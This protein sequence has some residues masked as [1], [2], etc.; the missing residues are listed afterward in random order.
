ML[1]GC[2]KKRHT[3]R[4]SE[5]SGK[6]DKSV[7]VIGFLSTFCIDCAWRLVHRSL[8]HRMK[9]LEVSGILLVVDRVDGANEEI[10]HERC[11]Q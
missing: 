9:G 1:R 4:G 10:C 7:A 5:L 6:G 8:P 3:L 11:S 2:V